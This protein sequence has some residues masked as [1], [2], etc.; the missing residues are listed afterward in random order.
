MILFT[1]ELCNGGRWTVDGGRWTVDGGRWTLDGT[2]NI[3]N[4]SIVSKKDLA[5]AS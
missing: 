1:K 3:Y 2:R 5:V 4:T